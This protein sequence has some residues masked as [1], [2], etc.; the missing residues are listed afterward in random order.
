[1]KADDDRDDDRP[2]GADRAGRSDRS[3]RAAR[4]PEPV[5]DSWVKALTPEELAAMPRKILGPVTLAER[6]GV[7]VHSFK[8]SICDLEFVV[9]SWQADRHGVGRTYCPECG[10]PTP[11]LHWR[12]QTS[13]SVTFGGG[14]A[15]TEI[16]RMCPLVD[17]PML[18]DSVP[19][20]DDRFDV[21]PP[22]DTVPDAPPTG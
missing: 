19:A 11:M 12:G 20:A 10:Y 17:G 2:D 5:N 9:F 7:F 15:G 22:D 1:M 13:W 6:E 4:V 16:Y 14:P 21:G 8:C 3:D 18:D